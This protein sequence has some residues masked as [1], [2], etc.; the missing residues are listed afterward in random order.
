MLWSSKLGYLRI[1]DDYALEQVEL[2]RVELNLEKNDRVYTLEFDYLETEKGIISNH[3]SVYNKD[4]NGEILLNATDGNSGQW[5]VYFHVDSGTIRDALPDWS[6]ADFEGRVGYGYSVMGGIL[7]GTVVNEGQSDAHSMLYWIAPGAEAAEILKLPGEGT[8][9][10]EQDTVFYQNEVGQLYRMNEH[11]QFELI[12]DYETMDYL[13][14]ELLTVS[15][16]GKLGILD[17][18]TGELYVFEEIKVSREDTLDYRAIRYGADG[19]IALAQTQWCHD[20]ERIVLRSLGVLDK[21]TAELKTMKIEHDYDAYQHSWLDENRF[22]VIYKTGI[23]QF[24]CVYEF[25]A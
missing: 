17:A 12:C 22:A 23:G 13:Q 24:L 5:P 9:H 19:T 6:A 10:V 11:F 4:E 7:I 2:N 16:R 15:V 20:P 18:Y 8:H 1:A 21:E 3:R 14:D 25:D